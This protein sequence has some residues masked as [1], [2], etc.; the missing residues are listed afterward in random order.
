MAENKTTKSSHQ[1]SQLTDSQQIEVNKLS[2]EKNKQAK[3]IQASN[4]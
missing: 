1:N 4:T 3:G 2:K